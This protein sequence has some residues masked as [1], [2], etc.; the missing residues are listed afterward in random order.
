MTCEAAEV[1]L[2]NDRLGKRSPE[3]D[4]ALPIISSRVRDDAFQR[5]RH[6]I[7]G[8]ASCVSITDLR[9]GDAPSIWIEQHLLRI[10]PEPS[11]RVERPCHAISIDLSRSDARHEHV[12]V[13]V[14]AVLP[15][16]EFYDP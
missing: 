2:V 7:A 8:L 3:R 1:H 10:E 14:C 6:V 9:P 15:R 12:P 13:M 5:R 16:I 11:C 4:I